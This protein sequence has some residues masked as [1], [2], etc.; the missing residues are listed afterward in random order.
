ML[1]SYVYFQVILLGRTIATK[2]ASIR[3]FSSVDTPMNV[4]VVFT[5]KTPI[6]K[7]TNKGFA[8]RIAHHFSAPV[9]K[10]RLWVPFGELLM[11]GNE[12]SLKNRKKI[13]SAI[14]LKF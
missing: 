11:K 12:F 10:F 14:F 3:L 8:S 7:I 9:R 13:H 5:C 1:A 2:L 6:A 4:Q